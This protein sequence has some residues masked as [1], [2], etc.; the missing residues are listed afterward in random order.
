[1]KENVPITFQVA[2]VGLWQLFVYKKEV[3]I[4]FGGKL[5]QARNPYT[6]FT[7]L[8]KLAESKNVKIREAVAANPNVQVHVMEDFTKDSSPKVRAALASNPKLSL[9]VWTILKEDNDSQVSSVLNE[10]HPT[11]PEAKSHRA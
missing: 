8:R 5:K 1:M 10:T 4:M 11:A 6:T 9:K 2:N 7:V 3:I